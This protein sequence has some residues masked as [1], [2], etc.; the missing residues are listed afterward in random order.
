MANFPDELSV[1]VLSSLV[2]Y[3]PDEKEQKAL[4]DFTGIAEYNEHIVPMSLMPAC[5][6]PSQPPPKY[7][8]QVTPS[9]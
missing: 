5:R 8:V 6:T 1:N 4:L 7:C 9:C 2:R 3:A